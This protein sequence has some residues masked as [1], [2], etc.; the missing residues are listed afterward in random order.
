MLPLPL[1]ASVT[2]F[3]SLCSIAFPDS[4]FRNGSI[5]AGACP[6]YSKPAHHLSCG[7]FLSR[8][9]CGE[10]FLVSQLLGFCLYAEARL[11]YQLGRIDKGD[12]MTLA[13]GAVFGLRP[14]FAVTVC[15]ADCCSCTMLLPVLEHS[16]EAP[17]SRVTETDSVDP[18]GS[19]IAWARSCLSTLLISSTVWWRAR[20]SAQDHGA[21]GRFQASTPGFK[22]ITGRFYQSLHCS[23]LIAALFRDVGFLRYWTISNHHCS[24]SQR[25]CSTLWVNQHFGVGP[26]V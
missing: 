22:I 10:P 12:L 11:A 18:R 25:Q 26:K 8:A 14:L 20:I 2:C 5:Q 7:S 19:C 9:V 21:R 15:L 4:S 17:L 23:N 3:R 24:F 13:S 1:R 16:L 6:S